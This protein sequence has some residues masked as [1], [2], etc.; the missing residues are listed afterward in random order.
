MIHKHELHKALRAA[1]E[2][3][4]RNNDVRKE[5]VTDKMFLEELTPWFEQY[6]EERCKEAVE[7]AQNGDQEE[8]QNSDGGDE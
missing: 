3:A 4:K 7:E 8:D 2:S 1:M 6:I 5:Y